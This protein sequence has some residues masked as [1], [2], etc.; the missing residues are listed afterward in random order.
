MDDN[1]SEDEDDSDDNDESEDDADENKSED[2]NDESIP[3]KQEDDV[4]ETKSSAKN[5]NISVKEFLATPSA[6][7]FLALGP[8]RIEV[9]LEESKVIIIL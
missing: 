5:I 7:N 9:L 3:D 1:E 8:D 6:D 4:Q 2:D